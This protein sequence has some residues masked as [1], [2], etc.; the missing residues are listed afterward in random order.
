M[1]LDEIHKL[2][3]YL[4]EKRGDS[5]Q[6]FI[7]YDGNTTIIIE[8][9]NYG[10]YEH[11]IRIIDIRHLYS[12]NMKYDYTNIYSI[13]TIYNNIDKVFNF[14][15]EYGSWYII[16]KGME[17]YIITKQTVGN[18]I[19]CGRFFDAGNNLREYYFSRNKICF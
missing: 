16:Q 12:F 10:F 6:L 3:D 13:S 14:I 4:I 15:K 11:E 19:I 9:N 2:Y 5:K 18:D 8:F 17:K 7:G 1:N